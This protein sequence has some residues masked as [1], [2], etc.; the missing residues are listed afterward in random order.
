M[1]KPSV[2]LIGENGN[3]M[4]LLSICTRALKRDGQAE[5]AREL[6]QKIFNAASYKDALKILGEYVNIK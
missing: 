4:N 3:T 1:K 5:K 2:K 6:T